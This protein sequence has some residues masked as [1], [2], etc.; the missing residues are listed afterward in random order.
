[1][2]PHAYYQDWLQYWNTLPDLLASVVWFLAACLVAIAARRLVAG[3][4]CLFRFDRL[5]DRAGINE[6]LR[7]GR[8]N[9]TPSRLLGVFA[10]WLLILIGLFRAA[11][12]LDPGITQNLA[13]RV[14]HTLPGL[15]AACMVAVVGLL[16][17][18]FAVQVVRTLARN[19]G[20]PYADL[21]AQVTRLAGVFIVIA[22]A[23]EQ[24]EV[25]RAII[26]ATFIILLAALGLGL[27]LA[28]G[29]GCRDMARD[30]MDRFLREIRER[31]RTAGRGDLEG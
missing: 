25:G 17:V 29:L 27:A 14:A 23:A 1:M 20:S 13:N 19:A 12:R 10:F 24:L 5:C 30:A 15:A 22:A 8:V 9:Y 21:L 6:V 26:L 11:R 16:L 7:T 2:N 4:L 31:S 3:A 18:S 28:F